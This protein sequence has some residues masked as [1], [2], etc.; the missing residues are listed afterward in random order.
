[1]IHH[2]VFDCMV[3]LQA[4]TN[5]R[6]PASACLRLVEEK[7]LSLIISAPI[8]TEVQDVFARPKIRAK[9]PHLTDERV[10]AFFRWIG[11]QGV[12]LNEVPQAFSYS[13]DPDDEPYI[14][15]AIAG[16]ARYL[17]SWDKDLLDL[18]ADA[19]FRQHFPNLIILDPVTL[20]REFALEQQDRGTG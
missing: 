4:V 14:N 18:M 20:L 8:L 5:E 11:E 13:R 17:V 9:F 10:E 15:L 12:T 6:G 1:M 16:N 19:T 2:A 7:R 3:L